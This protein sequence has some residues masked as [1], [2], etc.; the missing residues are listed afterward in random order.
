MRHGQVERRTLDYTRHRRGEGLHAEHD[1]PETEA[2]LDPS[3]TG[4]EQAD[5][6]KRQALR[7]P[8]AL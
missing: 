5:H 6:G 4:Q 1:H 7:G 2:P 3:G 8:P